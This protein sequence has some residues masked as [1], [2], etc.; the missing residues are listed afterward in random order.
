M[1]KS[2]ARSALLY[3]VLCAASIT[4]A[5]S[6][7]EPEDVRAREQI[8]IVGLGLQVSPAHQTVPK[9]TATAVNTAMAQASPEA[10]ELPGIPPDALVLAELRG[11]AFSAP[12]MLSARPNEPMA[13]PPLALSGLYVLDDIRLVSGGETILR[14][15]PD[16]V[17][18]EVIDKVIETQVTSRALT[19]QEILEKGIFID[20]ENFQVVNFTVAFGVQDRKVVIDFPMLV[21]N[22]PG[23]DQPPALP[24]P[25]LPPLQPAAVPQATSQLPLLN[26]AFATPNVSVSGLLL[27]VDDEQFDNVQLQLPPIPGVIVIPGNIAF[28]NQFFS[29][30]LMVSNVAPFTSNLVVRDL[31]AEILLPSGDDTVIDTGDDPLRMARLGEPPEEQ[32][33]IQ[34]VVQVGPDEAL[35]TADDVPLVRPGQNGDAEFLVEGR[36]EG[37]HTLRMK[38]TGKL[39]GLPVGPVSVSGEAVGVVEVR[40]PTFSLTLS[41]PAT[42]T[43]G[44]EYDLLVTVT[45]TSE[46]PANFVSLSLLPR[47]ISGAELLSDETVQIETIGRASSETVTFR[48]LS[49]TTGNVVAT[50]FNSEGIPGKFDLRTA[51]GALDIP[52]SPNSLV[53]P[54]TANALPKEIRDAGVGFLGQAF[55][56]AT[57]PVTPQGLLPLTRQ[58][59]YDRAT[60]LAAA[61]Q[62]L[63]MEESLPS[64]ARDLALDFIGNN[65]TRLEERFEPDE[66]VLRE[67]AE[68][69]FR[70]FDELLRQSDRGHG[71]LDLL[72]DVLAEDVLSLGV[73]SFQETFALSTASRPAYISAITGSGA[74]PAPVV[75]SLTDPQSKRL[76]LRTAGEAVERAIP[77]GAFFSL[78]DADPEFSHMAVVAVPEPGRHTVAVSGTGAG[79]FDLGL[80]VPEGGALR[81]L[82][83]EGVGIQ[84]G[85]K[86]RVV[87]TI[88][89]VNGYLLEV[90]ETGDGIFERQL[91]PDVNQIVSDPGPTLVSAN[92]ILTRRQDLSRYGQLV[93]VLFSEEI[94]EASS[95]SGLGPSGITHYAIEENQVVAASLQPGGRVVLLALRD[96][97]GPFISRNLTTTDIEDRLQ[98]PMEPPSGTVPIVPLSDLEGGTVSGRVRRG[99]GT[100]VPRARVRLIQKDL[101]EGSAGAL[102]TDPGG[103][104]DVTITVKDAD[105]SGHYAFDFIRAL[106]STF[107]AVDLETGEKGEAR[108]QIRFNGQHLDLDI[109]L[110]GAATLVGRALGPDGVTPLGGTVV[111]VQSLTRFGEL[112][113]AVADAS[114]AYFISGIPVG[115]VTVEAVH[116]ASQ[117]RTLVAANL[118]EAGAVVVQDL[119]LIPLTESELETGTLKGQVFRSDGATPASGIPV[120]TDRGGLDT[121]DNAGNYRIE[122]LPAGPI[123]VRAID[124]SLL[125][126]ASVQTTIVGDE[127]ITANLLL[128]GGTGRVRGVVLDADGTPIVGAIVGGGLTLKQTDA[129]GAFI[130]DDVPVGSRTITA[131]HEASGR[132]ASV[133][134]NLTGPGQE[135][136]VQIILPAHGT[137]VGKV[138]EADGQTPVPNIK[139]F[140]LGPE[141]R[142]GLTDANGDYR[143]ENLPL[144]SYLISA[145]RPEFVDG[146]VTQAK[147]VFKDEVRRADVVFRGKGRI[148]GVVL[149]D[150]GVTPLLARVGLRR[151]QVKVA[152][153]APPDN[154]RCTIEGNIQVGDQ[155]IE[156]PQCET[157]GIGFEVAPELTIFDTDTTGEFVFEDL[158]VG[159][160][161]VEAANAF[162]PEIIAARADIQRA[163]DSVHVVLKLK[164]TSE[165]TGT[166]FQPDG[167]TPVGEDVVVTY[168]GPTIRG[169]KVVTD[170][171]G[172]YRFP[173]VTEGSFNVTAEDPV[174]G[175]GGQSS[176][177]VEAG[178]SADIS[179]RLLGKG[180]VTVEVVGS[181]GLI[182]GALVK[183][184][185]GSFP[186]EE[187]QGFTGSDGRITFAGG[188][189]ITEGPFSVSAFDSSSGITGFASDVLPSPDADVE[190][191]IVLPDE[192]GTVRG[193]FL[194]TDGTT[195]IPNAQ[196]ALSA[197]GG[198]AFDTTGAD[199]SFLFEGVL[200]GGFGL[201]A[202]DATTARRGKS[203]G[204]IALNGEE[205]TAD[206]VEVPQGTV[207]GRVLLSKDSSPIAGAEVS[208]QV[209]SV[210][211]ESLRTTSGVDGAFTFPA[212]SAGNFMLS[213]RDFVTGF[214]GTE[215]GS[216]AFEGE[217]VEVDVVIEVPAKGRVEGVV[218]EADGN[219]ALAAQVTLTGRNTTVDNNGFYFFEDVPLGDV[220]LLA[221]AAI[222]P[223][224]G[225]GTGNV[226]FD[227]DIERVDIQFVGT[228]RVTGTVTNASGDPIPFARIVL[229]RKTAV[230]RSF[231]AETLTDPD[232]AFAF[233]PVLVGELS[234]TATQPATQLGGTASGTLA[235]DGATLDL[236][237]V[238]E[239]SGG[240]VGRVLRE[241]GVTPAGGMAL[242]LLN[243]SSRFGSTEDEGTFAFSDLPLGAYRLNVTDPLGLGL[244]TATPVL[245]IQGE[246]IDLGDLVLD[247]S[248]PRVVS[249][250]PP[251]GAA[252]V[253]VVQVVEV[254]FSEPVDPATVQPANLIVSTAEGAVAGIWSL[255][256]DGRRASFTPAAPYRDFAQVN[257]K[258]TT[259]VKDRVGRPLQA[260]VVSSFITADS[261]A[262]STV[263]V[264]P[265]PDARDVALNAV[266]RIGYSEVIAPGA[267]SGPAIG[268]SKG[269]VPVAGRV[270]F[271]LS[272]TVV[273]FTPAALLAADALFQVDVL[274]VT[275]LFG[276]TQAAGLSYSFATL[277]TVPPA[278]ESL[279]APGGTEVLEG[280]TAQVT[281][282]VGAAIDVAFVEFFLN[283]QSVKTVSSPPFVFSFAVAPS[284]GTEITVAARATDR[285]GN[286]GPTRTVVLTVQT[287]AP[288]TVSITAPAEGTVVNAGT[289]L[290][291]AA[292]AQ[293]DFGVQRV[294]FQAS[295][296][297]NASRTKSVTPPALSHDAT[298]DLDIPAN[299]RPGA[300][301]LRVVAIDTRDQA[302]TAALVSVIVPDT[303][304]PLVQIVSPTAGSRVEPGETVNVVVAAQDN[305]TVAFIRLQ[306]S[307]LAV[308][309]ESRA[310]TP[311]ASSAQAI[312]QVAIPPTATGSDSLSLTARA[313]DS[314]GNASEVGPVTLRVQDVDSPVVSLSVKDG[315]TQVIRGGS[316]TVTVSA[317]DAVGVSR[318]GFET[319]GA[320]VVTG[321]Q[322]ISPAQAS[323][324]KDF[325]IP[326]PVSAPLG[327]IVNI[328]GTAGDEDGNTGT[329]S[330][331]SLT[332]A[333]SRPPEVT[334]TA[335]ADGL[336]VTEGTTLVLSADATDDAAVTQVEF[337][338]D[339]LS[340][341]IDTEAPFSLEHIVQGGTDRS[342]VAIEA[343]ATDSDGQAAVDTVTIIRRD[344]LEPPTI[345]IRAPLDGA[346]LPVG[347]SDVALVIDASFVTIFSSG[348]D[349]DGDGSEETLLEAEILTAKAFLDL[350]DPARTRVAV[351]RF[352]D[353]AEIVQPLTDNRA[354]ALQALDE[355]RGSSPSGNASFSQALKTATDELVGLRARREATP[356]ELFLSVG[357][358]SL[359]RSELSR[360]SEGGVRVNTVGLAS[361]AS[362]TL[363]DAMAE[364]TGGVFLPLPDP[365]ALDEVLSGVEVIPG[366]NRL[367]V[368]ADAGDDVAVRHV[369]LGVRSVDDTF[370]GTR[371]DAQSP[372]QGFFDVPVLGVELSVTARAFDFGENEATAIPVS[373]TVDPVQNAPEIRRL[374]PA[375]GQRGQVVRIV[376]R[377]FDPDPAKNKVSFNGLSAEIV[378]AT[379]ILVEARVPDAATDGPVTLEAGGIVSNG[380]DFGIDSD[381]DGLSD[382]EEATAGTDPAN[383]D[384]DGDGLVDGDEVHVIGTDPLNLDTDGDGLRDGFEVLH[385]FNP[386]LGGDGAGDA[387]AD[388]LSNL[389]EQTRGT[390]PRNRD[391]DGD[392][393]RDGFEVAH[394]FDPLSPG[395]ASQD[396]DGDGLTNL[397]EQSA[398]TH[399]NTADTD[400]DGLTDG[401]EIDVY[402][403]NP[404]DVDT[405]DDGLLDGREVNEQGT[406][407]KDP[408]TDNGGRSD[409]EEVLVDGTNPLDPADDI[410]PADRVR[411]TDGF[412]LADDAMPAVD[413]E[414]NV[415]VAWMDARTGNREIFYAMISPSGTVRIGATPLTSDASPSDRPALAIDSLGRVNVVWQ[416]ERTE[417][418]YTLIDPRL[419]NRDGSPADPAAITVVDDRLLSVAD[420]HR[421]VRPR[422]AVDHQDRVHVVW[423]DEDD[424]VVYYAQLDSGGNVTVPARAIFRFGGWRLQ[425]LPDVA[426][427]SSGNAHVVWSELRGTS[428]P[429][430]FYAMIDGET[431]ESRIDATLL[432]AND[433]E[434][435]RFPSVGVG[436]DDQVTVVFQDQ[437]LP[438]G[439][440]FMLRLDPSRDDQNGD[441]SFRGRL[442]TLPDTVISPADGTKSNHPTAIVDALGRVHLTY[443]DDWDP[444]FDRG[445]LRFRILSPSG[446]LLLEEPLTQGATAR[447]PGDLTFTRGFVAV[448]G[449]ASYVTWTD[450]EVGQPQII[451]GIVR[452][453]DG[454]GL[455]DSRERERGTD[456]QEP[457]SD[458]DGLLDGFET[459]HG[460]DPLVP[461]DGTADPDGDALSNVEEQ[462]A[463]TNPNQ[464]DTDGDGLD[465]REEVVVHETDPTRPDTDRGGRN[466][467]EEIVLDGT[468]PLDP[469]DDRVPVNLSLNLFDGANFLW[470]IQGDGDINRG[471]DNAYNGGLFLQVGGDFFGFFRNAVAEG[472]REVVI[473]PDEISGVRVTRKVFVPD[474][475]AFARFLEILENA[476]P[477]ELA[478][479]VRIRSR[480]STTSNSQIVT[481]SSGDQSFDASDDFLVTDGLDDGSSSPTMVHALSGPG[482]ALE[483]SSVYAV[484]GNQDFQYR[485]DVN[486]PAGGRVILMH[487]ASQNPNRA[488]AAVSAQRL[489]NLQGSA[490]KGLSRE[491]QKA[492]VNFD[493][494]KDADDDGL[495]DD[496]EVDL[497]TDPANPD[498][499]G[500]GLL[501]GF[502]VAHG[503]DPLAAGDGGLDPDNDGLDGLAEQAARTDP[504]DT[505][506][507]DDGLSD[508]DE[509]L[510]HATDPTA[511]DTDRDGLTD[512]AEVSA[513]GTNPANRDSDGDS[514]SDGQEISL[515]LNPNAP[516]SDGD[517]LFDGFEVETGLDPKDPA[518]GAADPDGDG[519]DNPGEQA[520]GTD[521]FDADTDDDG[522]TDREELGIDPLNFD[523]DEAGR[524]DG[525]EVLTDETDPLNPADDI[526]VAI[527]LPTVLFDGT[528]FRWDISHHGHT[529]VGTDLSVN[530]VQFIFFDLAFGESGGRELRIGP[531]ARGDLQV[532]RKIF[533]PVDDGFARFLEILENTGPQDLPA[534]VR[535]Q[536]DLH[537][538]QATL[539]VTTSSGDSAFDASDDYLITDDEED[540]SRAPTIVHA[541]SGP[542]A[543]VEPSSVTA[544]S[545]SDLVR[546]RFD[547]TV[548]AG[549]RVIL[550]HFASQN[551]NQ[552]VARV[553]AERLRNLEGSA[554]KGLSREEQEDIVN[555]D[556]TR[557]ADDDG[558]LDKDE[559]AFGTD[560][561]NPDTDGDGLLDG[562]EARH[563]LDPLTGGEQ[564]LD[565]DADGLDNLLEQALGTDPFD[566]D[567]DHDGLDDAAEVRIHATDPTR[568]DTDRDGLKDGEEVNR[569]ATSPTLADTDGGGRSD[570]DEILI[571]GTDPLDGS[572]DLPVRLTPGTLSDE[573]MAAVDGER[574]VHVVWVDERTG[575][576]EIFYAMLSPAGQTRI[577]GT[578]LT[579]DSAA[580]EKPALAVD[581]ANRV[582]VVWE[583]Q[584]LGAPEVFHTLID[585]ALD[586]RDGSPA[587]DAAIVL[588]DDQLLSTSDGIESQNPRISVDG[589]GGSHIV[590]TE[591]GPFARF[592]IH[593]QKLDADGA[594]ALPERAVFAALGSRASG[595][596]AAVVVDSA[597]DVHLAAV[598]EGEDED[599]IL[600]AMLDG[601]TGA[602]R[603]DATF[604][605]FRRFLGDVSLGISPGDELALVFGTFQA[606]FT[607]RIDP[608]LDDQNGDPALASQIVTLPETRLIPSDRLGHF[609]EASVDRDGNLHLIYHENWDGQQSDVRFRLVD[610]VGVLL[611]E[612]KLTAR[613][614]VTNTGPFPRSSIA[615][616][617][618][619]SYVT[620]TDDRFGELE[621]LLWI[622]NKDSDGDGIPDR[623]ER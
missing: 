449:A 462:A 11:P 610:P 275:D 246:V 132:F 268:L 204:A 388:G 549:G 345:A 435:S 599:S 437:R 562:F 526:P 47:S 314:A 441:A 463:G 260:E 171:Q 51:V 236:S 557:D 134:V 331:V 74:G 105:A 178:R 265:A 42:V 77:Y 377:F 363:L 436:A 324:S 360:A 29:V 78:I 395:E 608:G 457:D 529:N 280:S 159:S 285:S 406:N 320:F 287:D 372:F 3:G 86:A 294:V 364:A 241:G 326:V 442:L 470:D 361:G 207:K 208:I 251:G 185:R 453:T 542:G 455:S 378:T 227:G 493:A 535:I 365:S 79:G 248:V 448:D 10:I 339:G 57:A 308:L 408:D 586:D 31:R 597:G 380:V 389:E 9:N 475:D 616:D 237:V 36:R 309:S 466:D 371:V 539:I 495:L 429:E 281:A 191:R 34:P 254:D 605:A 461:G 567:T 604:L 413:A 303:S 478:V 490:L 554:L 258:V 317:T 302:S 352:A 336:E 566:P 214:S 230:P 480:H 379:K 7:E 370:E 483:P 588:V 83:Y 67:L 484:P 160:Y 458:G 183:L 140:A 508:G 217:E 568:A 560:P 486:V 524:S 611:R 225:V 564:N 266:I 385:G 340:V 173:L 381:S 426:L 300:L 424:G 90:D 261:T 91:I 517:G 182:D 304:P 623:D 247:E 201:D 52:L 545:G 502:E 518:D 456:P 145:Y 22:Q 393:L 295:G 440:I 428:G 32:A 572:D 505:D 332:V 494:K 316:V 167:V 474:D 17:T 558:L 620:W 290:S 602:T 366:A 402:K 256:A 321:S 291:V 397:E 444:R 383:P 464:A 556:V 407:P 259:G 390:H 338:V 249:V 594:V 514:V 273:V 164:G 28:L 76:G 39:D 581:G 64:V 392:G 215:S 399:P 592:S 488:A 621:V 131:L 427:D 84:A 48:L 216:L 169:A 106:P 414:G 136:T 213:A 578:A 103:V 313:E 68:Q 350:F 573:A 587:L 166:V 262:P 153:L 38:I 43:A 130:L 511:A 451:L 127:E 356:V 205:V 100:E 297:T 548:P 543:A 353:A 184:R 416:D 394:G 528:G 619:T 155:T 206:I 403:T 288:P 541:F 547:V 369:E 571:D 489:R 422:L 59:V 112:F 44:E 252:G 118:P 476:G 170:A 387:D 497:G 198:Q 552:A 274:P 126:E 13:I 277:D 598:D 16:S 46:T 595:S 263:S 333:A 335:P 565:P 6:T 192:S 149:D 330:P 559:A 533:V 63:G 154:A 75:L 92:Q 226:A 589:A 289:T 382:S 139:V 72:G 503:L 94:S 359:P 212:V 114:G 142:P 531:E 479:T 534:S 583:D 108:T 500:D 368:V 375:I 267:L 98:N 344:D 504:K 146:N 512:G 219:S 40:N 197:S 238:L 538:G 110:L 113:G 312:F 298:F 591:V 220:A 55:A 97:I 527:F 37:T 579:N 88:G 410:P 278:L 255:S 396:P 584:R 221:T 354:L 1:R 283:G 111:R 14:G 447:A 224:A 522:L 614:T 286:V 203:S 123:K 477:H 242:E 307:G 515:G 487:F 5:A 218:L 23:L 27:R 264:S 348:V 412:S 525:E 590:W 439:E 546:Y 509:V 18:I 452:D 492:I 53:L 481:T 120:F 404:L 519:L 585:P 418:F 398:G 459:R 430:I 454:D 152:S 125:E 20:Q 617:G 186:N 337:L 343:I 498:T 465:D 69:D 431:G 537:T 189:A 341:G 102:S 563:G 101:V 409:G 61:G 156:I 233:D 296:A 373:V 420:G 172:K 177:T 342:T 596:R 469:T 446:K 133:T 311:P 319:S 124:Q 58:I 460:F 121:T 200:K 54:Q 33:K 401:E 400:A 540:E 419:D 521:P 582:H 244:A 85:G 347:P 96:G 386:L 89:E 65:F 151:L 95:Q 87:F 425:A 193:R 25:S 190:V 561:A 305:G 553:S 135:V 282:D 188:D 128:F 433:G 432:T 329:S 501:D 322:A 367:R 161:T 104:K 180:T 82:T 532:T 576:R 211:S 346:I 391:T 99:D 434:N 575:S 56:L 150:D 157:V 80:V 138:F 374:D 415:H 257:L 450:D 202:F 421:S 119:I 222:G 520:A 593:Y 411:L 496:E 116:Q 143:F 603:I 26:L 327:G 210:F 158:F 35:G 30:L 299:A 81:R 485:F 49:Q 328:V 175:L 147:L 334:L 270:D 107:E 93:G 357:L 417:I 601:A 310:I 144:G 45:N 507:D 325:E 187:R 574:N 555:F 606:P 24:L 228:G 467:R 550:M 613:G 551:P 269:G 577:G 355:L 272:N 523:T 163:G 243:G 482:A 471:T 293:D 570:G 148:T 196:V 536:I 473:G 231:S 179:I 60:E 4:N 240:L 253:P 622:V 235:T 491:E 71:F 530:D 384:S 600:Y 292:H 73:L 15:I 41:H 306:A 276:N 162:S 284:L 544:S 315:V 109:I 129:N 250:T 445:R 358:G 12:V 443:Y 580:S 607:M 8:L 137:L 438:S 506:T 376:G 569:Y 323:A 2:P 615:A 609:P 165:V 174:T 245:A 239:P 66:I 362:S 195:G 50:A 229:M 199:G 62:R 181:N 279:T 351:V 618:G 349:V 318:L 194:R 21:P 472:G 117:S 513:H 468:N 423:S 223:D 510:I 405:D 115:N 209:N 122:G 232:G 612:Q 19:A 271:I 516:D 168:N 141:N 499:D 70:A 176:G 301:E 234:A